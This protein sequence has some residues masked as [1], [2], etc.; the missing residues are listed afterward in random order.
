MFLD[1]HN[2]LVVFTH[3]TVVIIQSHVK[4]IWLSLHHFLQRHSQYNILEDYL[5]VFY[6]G[7]NHLMDATI[8]E[9]VTLRKAILKYAHGQRPVFI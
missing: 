2:K 5:L 9:K 3:L 8:K 7:E 1:K 4:L 6:L